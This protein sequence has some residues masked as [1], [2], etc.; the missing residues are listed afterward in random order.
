MAVSCHVVVG[1][2]VEDGELILLALSLHIFLWWSWMLLLLA[3]YDRDARAA[4]EAALFEG[5]STAPK[6]GKR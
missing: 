1:A 4:A 2:A 3:G 6:K 5:L